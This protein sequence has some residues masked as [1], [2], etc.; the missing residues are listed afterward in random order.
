MDL[1]IK[2]RPATLEEVFGHKAVVNSLASLEQ[3]LP[4]TFLFYGPSGTGKTTLSRILI[5][6]IGCSS[7]AITEIDAATNTGVED[8]RKLLMSL[9]YQGFDSG[10]KLIILDECHMLSKSAWNALL[11]MLEEPPEHVYFALC[12]TELNKIP[13]TVQTRCHMYELKLLPDHE[14]EALLGRVC[15]EESLEQTF[16]YE[17]E[18]IFKE[19]VLAAQGS[20]RQALVLLSACAGLSEKSEILDILQSVSED[21]KEVIDFCRLL[22]K[23]EPTYKEVIS[24]LKGVSSRKLNPETV[25]IQ[26]VRYI[27]ACFLNS[28]DPGAF[29]ASADILDAFSAPIY[30]SVT[31]F[32]ELILQ[33]C[34]VTKE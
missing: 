31:G 11:K 30:N 26:I 1:H 4:H 24:F 22:I 5:N 19:L 12:T 16:V 25:R 20:P 23:R 14:I 8:A 33:C 18:D 13:K 17:E 27:T 2:K 21:D 10:K 6:L 29:L 7:N 3:N 15:E 28:R 32:Q 9:P 34:N